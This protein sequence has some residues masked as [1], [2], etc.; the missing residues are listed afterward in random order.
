MKYVSY[1]SLPLVLGLTIIYYILQKF[2]LVEIWAN[3]LQTGAAID[4]TFYLNLGVGILFLCLVGVI[5]LNA[6]LLIRKYESQKKVIVKILLILVIP[7]LGIVISGYPD[8]SILKGLKR[9]FEKKNIDVNRIQSWLSTVDTT[10]MQLKTQ[11]SC[12]STIFTDEIKKMLASLN[13]EHLYLNV[14]KD[15][16]AY[17]DLCYLNMFLDFGIAIGVQQKNYILLQDEVINTIE[18]QENAFIWLE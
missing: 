12:E 15:G 3:F 9:S 4:Q 10:E 8:H 17:L 11:I 13:P 2:I 14:G 5:I 16:K 1:L 6:V 7:N 18:L